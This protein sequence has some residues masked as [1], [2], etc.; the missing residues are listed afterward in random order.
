ML[1]LKCKKAER[2]AQTAAEM[3]F[4]DG[5]DRVD[6]VS[7]PGTSSDEN[8]DTD[9]AGLAQKWLNGSVSEGR[10][11]AES[12]GSSSTGST[13][14]ASGYPMPKVKPEKQETH[15]KKERK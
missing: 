13:S 1:W 15:K 4:G 10:V 8:E 2:D 3:H 6:V 7:S 5:D 14:Q 11:R 9:F 12:S